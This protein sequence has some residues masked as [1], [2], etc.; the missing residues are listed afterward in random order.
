MSLRLD[1]L[2][3]ASIAV[4]TPGLIRARLGRRAAFAHRPERDE[5]MTKSP[6]TTTTAEPEAPRKTTKLAALI[7]VLKRPDGAD[8]SAMMAATGWQSHSVRGALAGALK[9][10]GYRIESV[11]SDEV[12]LYRIVGRSDG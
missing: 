3:I 6:R 10:K 9:K 4:R 12:R 5:T 8:L 7:A 1:Y 11:K 2:R